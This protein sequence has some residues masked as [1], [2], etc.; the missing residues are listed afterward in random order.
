MVCTSGSMKAAC[1]AISNSKGQ[2]SDHLKQ[3]FSTRA[4]HQKHLES[5]QN[6]VAEVL[7]HTSEVRIFPV[8]ANA[9]ARVE[10]HSTKFTGVPLLNSENSQ[11]VLCSCLGRKGHK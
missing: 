9:A 2:Q 8:D 10:N 5:F 3:W 4:A 7:P 1:I 11:P 6:A